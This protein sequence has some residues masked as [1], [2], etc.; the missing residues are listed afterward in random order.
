MTRRKINITFLIALALL[1]IG[2]NKVYAYDQKEYKNDNGVI[3]TEKEYRF[4]NE[5]YG[6][7]YFN[8]MTQ[9]DYEWISILDIN[10]KD[11]VIGVA[12]NNKLLGN[13]LKG[14]QNS[15]YTTNSK[16]IAIAKSCDS[17][18]CN[19]ITSLMWLI[20]PVTRSY[21]VIG[22][23]FEGTSLFNNS[24]T[25]KVSSS[26]GTSYYS[27]NKILTNGFG[28]SVKLPNSATNI[29]VE[30]TFSTYVGGKIFASYQHAKN[31]I[32]LSNSYLYSLSANGYG[33]VF[34]FFGNALGIYDG[35]GGVSI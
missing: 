4:V 10:R 29:I 2:S 3:L 12:S 19:V 25:T 15:F 28:T 30:Q 34:N 26:S 20:N 27:N 16:R 18:K 9:E 11:V 6:K 33:K 13:N 14:I 22:A 17:T 31:N 5:F 23:R 24:I 1:I 8:K 32:T 35:M 7:T 21:D